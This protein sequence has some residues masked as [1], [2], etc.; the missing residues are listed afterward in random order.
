M[1]IAIILAAL[2]LAGCAS[3]PA[4]VSRLAP[5][6][7]IHT[8]KSVDQYTACVM[9]RMVDKWPFARSIP[10]PTGS[11]I[12]TDAASSIPKTMAVTD[13]NTSAT[14]AEV[15]FR[16]V[17]SYGDTPTVTESIVKSCI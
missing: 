7:T 5:M 6:F 15:T 12:L 11:R 16:Q 3:T 8:D 10:T 17:R 9:P 13:V 4:D 2:M 14:G 1:K